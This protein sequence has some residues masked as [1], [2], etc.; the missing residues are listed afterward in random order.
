LWPLEREAVLETVE[1]DLLKPFAL[2]LPNFNAVNEPSAFEMD[3]RDRRINIR[4]ADAGQLE[5]LLA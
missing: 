1:L 4:A 3:M 5:R 2:E